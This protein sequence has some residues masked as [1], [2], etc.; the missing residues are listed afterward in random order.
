MKEPTVITLDCPAC[1]GKVRVDFQHQQWQ[2]NKPAC[3]RFVSKDPHLQEEVLGKAAHFRATTVFAVRWWAKICELAPAD[4]RLEEVCEV[5]ARVVLEGRPDDERPTLLMA[6]A[7]ARIIEK[8][9]ANRA[10]LA[11]LEGLGLTPLPGATV[12]GDLLDTLDDMKRATKARV[13]H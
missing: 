6:W 9:H 11:W 1:N 5:A 10:P 8:E 4:A 12:I 7:A 2:H 13:R 3:K